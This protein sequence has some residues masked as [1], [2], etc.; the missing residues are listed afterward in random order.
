[1]SKSDLT[2]EHE[3]ETRAEATESEGEVG[4]SVNSKF[5]RR[6]V[7]GTGQFVDDINISGQ[8]H[9]R[10]V[11]SQLAHA[12]IVD[13]DTSEAEAMDGVELVWTG[14]D[15]EPYIEPYGLILP[16]EK[17]LSTDRA[18]FVGDELA[19]VVAKDR[20]TATLAAEKVDVEYER[21]D[22]VTG[23]DDALDDDAPILHPD[24]DADPDIDVDGNIASEYDLQVGDVGGAFEDAAVVV[25][26]TFE[27]NK[28]NP[29]PLEPKGCVA[30]YNPGE[31][32]LTLHS[33]N[34]A[35]HLMKEYLSEALA[36]LAPSNIVVKIPDIGGGFGVKIEAFPHEVCASALSMALGRPIKLVLDR[37][38]E[39]QAGRGRHDERLNARL[40]LDDDGDIVGW[41]VEVLQSTGAHASF[42]P[43]VI[44]SAGITSA[45]P[46]Y[47]PN[48]HIRGK[49]L[50]TNV[51]PGSA[52]RG[53]GDPQY[54]FAREQLL[55]EACAEL[56]VDPMAI[57]RQNAP[58]L[59]DMPM[60]SP[61]GINW[62]GADIHECFDRVQD[63]INWDDHRNTGRTKDGKLRGVGMGTLMKR[64]GN[65]K[66]A[67]TESDAAVVQMNKFGE[68][69]VLIGTASIGQGT[70]T[71][72]VQ[73]VADTLGVTSEEVKPIIG[74]SDVTP[75][76]FGVWADRGTIIG[77]SAAAK[78]AEDLK[79]NLRPLA[80]LMLDVDE[81]AVEFAGGGVRETGNPNNAVPMADLAHEATFANPEDRPDEMKDGIP[82]VGRARFDSQ[83]AEVPDPK[84]SLSHGYTWGC[85]AVVVDIDPT[86]GEIDVVDVAISED[87]GKAINPK[88][89][90]GQT[91][92][93]IAQ[94]LGEVLLEHYDYDGSGNLTNGSL[95]D[96]H[97]PTAKDVPLIN[98]IDEVETPDPT[99]SHGQKGV[100]E[101]PLVP[102]PAAVA[103][104]V[105]DATG[106]RFT[107]LPLTPDR[108]LPRLVEEGMREL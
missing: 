8:R 87:V 104:A 60:R 27:T 93:A 100:G 74:D 58:E 34:Q 59:E 25:E 105:A 66:V 50:Y 73:I 63:M 9:A 24:L 62:R 90:E 79:E 65:K 31:Q 40:A 38:E 30:D 98:K 12:R 23:V 92:G 48:Q 33:S 102:V 36:D 54:T 80:A 6:L 26:D 86:T 35:P 20:L 82:L 42:G 70:E 2:Q 72:I 91:Q 64:G 10:F 108:V 78:A 83:E 57:R 53:F 99:T 56:G 77:G 37:L 4:K 61:T 49:A 46:Y 95:V 75:E 11:R 55:E 69:T 3:Q 22:T 71:G 44:S 76:G 89:I 43:A 39:M 106:I 103:N 15:L 85:L 45:G 67:G 19:V 94:A 88:M 68:I 84:G 18:R 28:T 21:L 5:G 1:M 51:M 107:E 16:D 81:D 97:L 41:D 17:P 7:T 101:C 96:Y 13:I 47:I 52:V 29:T 14:E 32:E